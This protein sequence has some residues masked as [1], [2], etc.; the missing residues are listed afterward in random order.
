MKFYFYLIPIVLLSGCKQSNSNESMVPEKKLNPTQVI[1]IDS[2][3]IKAKLSTDQYEELTAIVDT[4]QLEKKYGKQWDFCDC[5]Y[6]TDSINKAIEN[7]ETLTDMEITNLFNRFEVI[8]L[9]CKILISGANTT[10]EERKN[11]Q[12]KVKQCKKSL[13]I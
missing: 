7:S 5:I 4:V 8:D 10:P 13:G 2:A 9:H 6:K 3:T 12:R 11:H 1:T